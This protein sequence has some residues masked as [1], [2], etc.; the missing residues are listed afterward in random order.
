MPLSDI[1]LE[2]IPLADIPLADTP[3]A[4][5]PLSD[6]PLADVPLS[7]IVLSRFPLSDIPLSDVP[8]ADTPLA[9]IPLAD[10]AQPEAI[11]VGSCSALTIE[12]CT[13]QSSLAYGDILAALSPSARIRLA[14]FVAAVDAKGKL[15]PEDT[16]GLLLYSLSL[17]VYGSYLALPAF[18]SLLQPGPEEYLDTLTVEGLI[19]IVENADG[20]NHT[21]AD[22][23]ALLIRSDTLGWER[24]DLKQARVQEVSTNGGEVTYTA[25][26]GLNSSPG[27]PS[28]SSE[29]RS[30]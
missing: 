28:G 18:E 7:D 19:G 10:V 14:E 15:L 21:L 2:D 11:F 9:D 22:L 27:G 26:I 25:R 16:L 4:D 29:T 3:L 24:L 30:R 13:L 5:T 23:L 6:T 12:G 8:L 17:P 1:P 20:V